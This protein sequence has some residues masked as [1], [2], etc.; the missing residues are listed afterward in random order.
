MMYDQN[1]LNINLLYLKQNHNKLLLSNFLFK[2]LQ[3][4]ILNR[5]AEFGKLE[6][7]C[8]PHWHKI[9]SLKRKM[10]ILKVDGDVLKNKVQ[11]LNA[12][13]PLPSMV[14]PD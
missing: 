11:E 7:E 6:S 10:S 1:Y 4:A 8:K 14:S 3:D 12:L 9:Q 13:P 5:A 2:C